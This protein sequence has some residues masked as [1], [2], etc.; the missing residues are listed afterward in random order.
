MIDT[1]NVSI[2]IVSGLVALSIFSSLL[3]FR[4]GAPMLLVFLGVG[5]IAGEDG[6]GGLHFDNVNAAYL[7]GS[8]ALAVILF[9]SGFHTDI[10]AFRVAAW[11]AMSLA[12]LGV[13]MTTAVVA[14]PVHFLLDLGWLESALMGAIASSTDAA[15]VFFLLRVGGIHVRDRVRSTLE[16]ESGSNDPMAIFLTLTLVTLLGTPQKIPTLHI[17]AEFGA[18]FGV[19]ALI[20]LAGGGLI[21]FALNRMGFERGLQPLAAISLALVVF[22]AAGELHGSGFLA[23]YIAGLV[24]G[25]ARINAPETMRRFQDGLTW[26]AQIVMFLTLG[27]LATPSEFPRLAPAALGIAAVL[28]LVARP[29]AVWLC[30]LPFGFNRNETAFVAWVGLRGS[31][32][33][34]LSIVPMVAGLPQARDY[35]IVA[36]LV[37]LASLGLQGWT[38]GRVARFLGQIV[39]KRIGPV[40][41]QE[42]EI[43]GA[44]H[45]LVAYRVVADSLVA[46][47]HRLPRWAAPSLVVR[48]DK[49][50]SA[51]AAGHLRPGDTAYLFARPERVPHL[52]RLFASAAPAAEADRQFFGDFALAPDIHMKEL[53]LSYGLPVPVTDFEMTVA[54]WMIRQL[55]HSPGTGDRV[56]LGEVELIVR[57]LD[58]D[59]TISEVG[60]AV[61]PTPIDKPKLPLFQSQA[62]LRG[63]VRRW[64]GKGAT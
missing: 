29:L 57:A 38:I 6:L 26:L 35:F 39:P 58:W 13:F 44:R 32:S 27:L 47:G 19:G 15:A 21:V 14:V 34:L 36:F 59:D 33:V 64:L 24:A 3:S 2:L 62:E 10:K 61:E 60:L 5:L 43:P 12:S 40:E 4:I 63:M 56:P 16:V 25:N 42:L 7:I 41:R 53:A 22:A 31:V 49:S 48:D 46:R 9:D 55:G 52:D 50:Y 23:V 54:N 8:V 51:H 37:V 45:E 11:P 28:I 20:G 1:M 17:I 18:Q 30:L